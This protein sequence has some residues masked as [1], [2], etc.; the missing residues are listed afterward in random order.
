MSVERTR[1]R[2][3]SNAAWIVGIVLAGLF[4]I[5]LLMVLL[6][7]RTTDDE[8]AVTPSAS[9]TAPATP[10]PASSPTQPPTQR[11]TTDP[12]I[13]P[14]PSETELADREPTRDDIEQ[15]VQAY[16]PAAETALGDVTG[17]GIGEVVLAEIRNNEVQIQV[18]VW[19]GGRYEPAYRD[20][21]GPAE[22][23]TRLQVVDHN[24][25]PGAEIVTQQAA[26]A[27][28]NSI[29]VWG[30]ADGR[31]ERQEAEGGCWDGSHTYGISGATITEDG[32]TA[33]CD[34]SPQPPEEWSSDVYEWKDGR[35]TYVR[36]EESAP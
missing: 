7:D 14:L 31:F 9:A 33:T 21:G 24:D 20:S 1:P 3:G 23:I 16:G 25:V 15:F 22:E 12:T 4:V 36:T 27:E 28:G 8:V 30:G 13:A 35:W 5:A 10:T 29:S 19:T 26:G 6:P 17:D 32:I 2:R 18:G 34:G 11:P